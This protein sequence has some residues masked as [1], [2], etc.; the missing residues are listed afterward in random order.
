MNTTTFSSSFPKWFW[1]AAA[2]GFAWN[3]FGVVQFFSTFGGTRES[4]MHG[5]MTQPQAD[6]YLRLPLWM[7]VSFAVGVFGGVVGSILLLLRRSFAVPVFLVSLVA[8]GVLYVGDITQGVFAAFGTPQ[9][10][11]LT[12]VV[13]IAIALLWLAL[14]FRKLGMLR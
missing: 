3:I 10:V 9:V 13:L 5:G 2:L 7:T 6:L 11:I 8:Y 14:H 4:L 12:T 1:V